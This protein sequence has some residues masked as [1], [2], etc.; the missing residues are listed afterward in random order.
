MQT[1]FDM[2]KT[3][4]S[5]E[6]LGKSYRISHHN[7]E[8]YLALRDVIAQTPKKL[9]SKLTPKKTADE[10]PNELFWA[11]KEISF[12]VK[13]GEVIGIIGRNGAG[14]STLLKV[15]SR[16]TDPSEGTVK[17]KGRIASL[18]EV[19]TGFHPELTGRENIYL[20]GAILGMKRQ[21]IKQQ[22]DKIAQF[23][24]IAQFLDTPVKRYSSGMQVRL[25]FAVAAHL[26][27][28]TLLVDEILAV[29]DIEFQKKCLGKM[30]EVSRSGRTVLFVSHNLGSIQQLCTKALVLKK[31][32]IAY[33]GK[34]DEAI[35]I[36]ISQNEDDTGEIGSEKFKNK[37]IKYIKLL[38]VNGKTSSRFGV[39]ST[40]QIQISFV[41]K[42]KLILPVIGIVIKDRY[43]VPILGVNNRHYG[44]SFS[45]FESQKG[46]FY[47][48]ISQFPVI[49][50]QYYIDLYLGDINGD[51]EKIEDASFFYMESDVGVTLS[52][53]LNRQ[54]NKI[55][56]KDI[57]WKIR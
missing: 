7:Q 46:I 35:S 56:I 54:L 40:I 32:Q 34:V 8:R 16:I 6:N 22:F 30:N 2:S 27:A 23:S 1:L 28:E 20:S 43:N 57:K 39:N 33:F 24:G 51:F 25:G 17:I 52:P 48:E 36:Y 55:F 11:L 18:L 41:A 53:D 47:I 45:D 14:K 5:I 15:L 31:G 19:G 21:E 3:V 9:L 13:Q 37:T 29:G 42:H 50:G 44:E 38:D 49:S 26:S 10:S 4:I 12:D